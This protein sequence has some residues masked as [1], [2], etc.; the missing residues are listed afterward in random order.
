ML[1]DFEQLKV[2]D[3]SGSRPSLDAPDV[4]LP[5]ALLAQ[6]VE[7]LKGNV[8]TRK[9]FG[10][11]RKNG[12]NPA[13]PNESMTA[14]FNW[15][16]D[17]ANSL[18]W[19]HPTTG[20]RYSAIS[21]PD[22]ITTIMATALGATASFAAD[23]TH[24]YSG[25]IDSTSKGA[26]QGQVFAFGQASADTL[27]SPPITY[28]PGAPTQPSAGT[29]TKGVHKIGYVIETR[30]GF[31][32]MPSPAVA[33][34]TFQPISFTAAGGRNI[35][36]TLNTTWPLYAKQ[37]RVIMT[38]VANPNRWYYV[39]AMTNLVPGG[40]AL[41]ITFVI[42]IT[43]NDLA[44]T[45]TGFS[46][47]AMK[48]LT[49]FTQD[50]NATGPFKPSVICNYNNRMCYLTSVPDL[51]A[52]TSSGVYVSESADYQ[53]I[54][55]DQHLLQA[56][57]RQ[58]L[59]TMMPLRSGLY[60]FGPHG[61]YQ[62]RDTGDVPVSWNVIQIDGGKGTL[63]PHGVC[64][65]QKGEYGWVADESGLF[66][67]NGI[68]P[69]LP[70]SYYA[71]S[72]WNRINWS[73]AHLVQVIDN[74]SA[75]KVMV[76][77][78]LD[79]STSALSALTFDYTN[80]TSCED[81]KYCGVYSVTGYNI[82]AGCV[83]QNDLPGT[84]TANLRKLEFW[85][86]PNSAGGILRQMSA[87]DSQMWRDNGASAIHTRYR[88]GLFSGDGQIME[89]YGAHMRLVGSGTIT[90]TAYTL[91]QA[92]SRTLRS[93]TLSPTPGKDELLKVDLR[94]EGLSYDFEHNVLDGWLLL[95]SIKHYFVPW[96]SER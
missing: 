30:S 16:H 92:T 71:T 94:S 43:D 25:F 57:G 11:A 60:L 29:V 2:T 35:S 95:S 20:V 12:S 87:A 26:D 28:N 39:P 17:S 53:S 73:A 76:L 62:T 90:P 46:T 54:T 89:H 55:A 50:T 6:N 67:F 83:A 69:D 48:L 47:S 68:Y 52:G 44:A 42:D 31:Q 91:D 58:E 93:V 84:S 77:A 72:D 82:G 15:I 56:P 41:S 37:V 51:V 4:V 80:G 18:V 61:T 9:G 65:S 78:P 14:V 34:P 70:T 85:F 36:W 79:G 96:A 49:A 33:G 75:S 22:G 64:R 13:W 32:T 81:I 86:G 45:D 5:N 88:T 74:K 23:G 38:T 24:L 63:A 10:I 40:S 21:A 8:M 59:T 3:F 1:D 7:F 19:F 66:V 27:F